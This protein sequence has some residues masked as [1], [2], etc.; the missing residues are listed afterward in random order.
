M[1][2]A[3]TEQVRQELSLVRVPDE[4]RAADELAVLLRLA[5]AFHRTGTPDGMVTTLEITSRSGA[6]V[7]RAFA[8]LQ[9][10][11]GVRM[12]LWVRAPAGVRQTATYGAT[13]A[14]VD[15][16]ATELGLLDARGRP[17]PG[18][19]P[20]GKRSPDDALRAAVLAGGSFSSPGRPVHV[21]FAVPGRQVGEE[22]RQ[23]LYER[24][25]AGTL[26]VR[27]RVVLKSGDAV[28]R[29][30][31][32][33]GAHGALG[34]WNDR[35]DR[36]RLRNE[37]T[38]LANADAANLRRSIAAAG[39]QVDAV[40]R[41]ITR[42]GWDALGDDLRTVA[43]ARLANPTATLAE[44]GQLCD[45]PVGKSAVHR[46]LQRLAELAA[47]PPDD[48]DATRPKDPRGRGRTPD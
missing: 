25:G 35:R 27:D 45:P 17:H 4:L 32:V 26:D 14:R 15:E 39:D 24:V 19:P 12:E 28:A 7:R 2:G 30:L 48:R 43:L 8:L 41:A 1:P 22:L 36:S 42:L 6:V 31:E 9:R 20:G 5:G 47:P 3:F 40:E 44:L 11:T 21:E 10:V 34:L 23:L 18:L 33:S 13:I 37:A 29:L 16:L 46:R 38:R